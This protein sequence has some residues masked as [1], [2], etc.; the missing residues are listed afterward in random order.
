MFTYANRT[1]NRLFCYR[2]FHL[3]SIYFYVF[4]VHEKIYEYI[5]FSVF[6]FKYGIFLLMDYIWSND[7]RYAVISSRIV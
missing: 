3:R 6:Y 5:L 2:D 7:N 4:V 1:D